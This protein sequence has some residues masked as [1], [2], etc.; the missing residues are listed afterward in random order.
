MHENWRQKNYIQQ[1]YKKKQFLSTVT[2]A[3]SD[4][5]RQFPV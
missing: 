1:N 4:A 5:S 3:A 2:F